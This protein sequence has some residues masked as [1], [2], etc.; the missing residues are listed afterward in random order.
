[1]EAV[2]G[3]TEQVGDEQPQRMRVLVR[4]VVGEVAGVGVVI[5]EAGAA[6]ER[7]VALAVLRERQR[8]VRAADANCPSG[9]P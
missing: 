8:F 3:E 2:R 6:F 4:G 1:M 7:R 5:D 9:S